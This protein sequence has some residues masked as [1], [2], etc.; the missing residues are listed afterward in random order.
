[1]NQGE[2]KTIEEKFK[3]LCELH[4][5]NLHLVGLDLTNNVHRATVEKLYKIHLNILEH[6]GQL[7]KYG[8]L[9]FLSLIVEVFLTFYFVDKAI[10][11]LSI[12]GFGSVLIGI[13]IC[14]CIFGIHYVKIKSSFARFRILLY[15]VIESS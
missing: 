2:V 1:M 14:A 13:L 12:L 8:I 15:R 4:S 9:L 5:M 7:K 3:E 10:N 11:L 6:V